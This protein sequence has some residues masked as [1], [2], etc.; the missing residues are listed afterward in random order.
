V[1]VVVVRWLSTRAYGV[2]E[3]TADSRVECGGDRG[4]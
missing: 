4:Q 2:D 1:L 3:L